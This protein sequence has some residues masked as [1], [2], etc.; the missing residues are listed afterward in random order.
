M[1]GGGRTWLSCSQG[2]VQRDCEEM[3]VYVY[4]SSPPHTGR[5]S[6]SPI[7]TWGS[8]SASHA[9][10]ARPPLARLL[11]GW[12]PPEPGLPGHLSVRGL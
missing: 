10:K 1:E 12:G 11:G 7:S 2:L 6:C 5:F 9:L 4:I 3:C 8:S